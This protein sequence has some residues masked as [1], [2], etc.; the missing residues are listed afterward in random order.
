MSLWKTFQRISELDRRMLALELEM[1]QFRLDADEMYERYRK[2][3]SRI[4]KRAAT[5][6]Q[7][8]QEPN[9]QGPE[10]ESS[11]TLPGPGLTPRQKAMQQMVLRRRAGIL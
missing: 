7:H 2:M 10:M 5:I 11:V 3:S 4:A 6:E 8:E 1:K 9:G